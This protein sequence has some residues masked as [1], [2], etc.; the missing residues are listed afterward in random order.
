M[1]SLREKAAIFKATEFE[2]N[3]LRV[4]RIK[5]EEKRK[6]MQQIEE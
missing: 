2:K 4:A 3:R 1:I 6:Y 5:D